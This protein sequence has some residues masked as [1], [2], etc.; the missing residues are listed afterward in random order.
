MARRYT[1]EQHAWIRG[2]YPTMGNAE[3][4]EAF[5]ERFCEPVTRDTMNAYGTNH[6]LRKAD[7]V[8]ERALRTYTDEENDFLR[9][10]IP[11]HSESEIADAFAER[12]GRRLRKSQ[13]ANRKTKLGVASGTH[14]GRF[15][16]G[17]TPANKGRTWDEFMSSEGQAASRRTQFRKG[18]RPHNAYHELLDEREDEDG[19]WVYVKPRNRRLA[20][21][22]WIPKGRFVWMRANGRDWP[23]GHRAV[24]ADRNRSNFDP[25]NIVP[26][27]N[28]LYP[29]VT[30][31][32][33]GHALPYHDRKSLE[34][35]ITHARVIHE[36]RRLELAPR[37]CKRCGGEFAPRFPRQRTCDECL[38]LRPKQM[39]I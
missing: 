4:A 23:E 34:V 7:G 8:K 27:P 18:E 10:F 12:F 14:G 3:L 30:G 21:Q 1:P 35:A 13:I 20:S 9:S 6:R 39:E 37:K 17:Q 36:R 25:D 33:H 15:V 22:N 16:K 28:D 19:A 29:I 24:F 5:V 2:H 26:V 38:G 32:A 11:G 31:G